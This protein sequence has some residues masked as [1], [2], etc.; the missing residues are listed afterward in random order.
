M[1]K[2]LFIFAFIFVFVSFCIYLLGL[3]RIIPFFLSVIPMFLSI[4]FTVHC[5]NNRN[6]FRG[7]KRK[8]LKG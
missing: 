8:S 4:L 1:N 7:N 3:M 6:R 2:F 5:W